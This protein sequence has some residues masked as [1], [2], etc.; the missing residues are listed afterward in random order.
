MFLGKRSGVTAHHQGISPLFGNHDT[1]T[2]PETALAVLTPF[3][4]QVSSRPFRD[5]YEYAGAVISL[6]LRRGITQ[7]RGSAAFGNLAATR[8]SPSTNYL[9]PGITQVSASWLDAHT[10][11]LRLIALS[12]RCN[13]R[14]PSPHGFPQE[15]VVPHKGCHTGVGVTVQSREPLFRVCSSIVFAQEST[16]SA[17][18]HTCPKLLADIEDARGIAQE[19]R[20][21]PS[22]RTGLCAVTPSCFSTDFGPYSCFAHSLK[23]G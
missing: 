19:A 3:I 12:S 8:L 23:V 2:Q 18:R 21:H 5:A 4:W 10:W 14:V 6:R 15:S 9:E 16:T 1:P 20:Q 22:R 13:S 7:R 17:Y 11:R